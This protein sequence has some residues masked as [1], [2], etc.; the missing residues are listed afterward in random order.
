MTPA[1]PAAA[2]ISLRMQGRLTWAALWWIIAI[3]AMWQLG[4]VLL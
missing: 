3:G 1:E 2:R 4:R